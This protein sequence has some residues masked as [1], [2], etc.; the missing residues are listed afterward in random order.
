M[1]NTPPDRDNSPQ[2]RLALPTG[3]LLSG[4]NLILFLAAVSLTPLITFVFNHPAANSMSLRLLLAGSGALA[5][6]FFLKFATAGRGDSER[7]SFW[8]CLAA[9]LTL[10]ASLY[11]WLSFI[12]EI[13][14]SPLTLSWSEASR[15]YYA[16]LFFSER[17]YG[18]FVPPTVLHPSRYLLQAVPF[19]VPD[20]PIWVHRAWQ[21]LLWVVAPLIA[22]FV[23]ARRLDIHD[24]IQRWFFIGLAFL[25]I[26][27]GPIYYHLLV[28]VVLVLWGFRPNGSNADWRRVIRSLLVVLVASAWAGISRV[29][30]FPLP[31]CLAALLILLET[32]VQ[33]RLEAS[34]RT[35]WRAVG[36][37]LLRLAGWVCFGTATAFGSQLLYILWSGNSA[38]QF[39]TSFRS[40]LLW[41]RLLP[42][43]TYPLGILPAITLVS[44]P[45]ALIILGRLLEP[46]AG[47]P[48]WRRIHPLRLLG[49]LGILAVFFLGGLLV[50]VKIGG[51]SNLHNMDAFL[52]L[53]LVIAAYFFYERTGLDLQPAPPP[54]ASIETPLETEGAERGRPPLPRLLINA[55]LGLGFLIFPLITVISRPPAGP[56]PDPAEVAKGVAVISRMVRSTVQDGGSVLFLSYRE[57]L[58]FHR[59]QAPL[60]PDY[61]RVFLMEVAMADDPDY[62]RRFSDELKSQRFDLIVSEPISLNQKPD[63]DKFA[64]ENNAWVK[65]VSRPLLCYYKPIKTLRNVQV[66]LLAPRKKIPAECP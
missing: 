45:L 49:M 34:V 3:G 7:F 30:W 27:S 14:N 39:T 31:G 58:T 4:L 25:F 40:S 17:I 12:P 35:S 24:R 32:P 52:A 42:S 38:S 18:Q 63:R 43:Q 54:E 44:L 64:A 66:Q 41:R 50:S 2:R 15:Y 11:L 65:N 23:L 20:S 26:M 48:R 51:G 55:G 47:V 60:I 61:E 57:L 33:A 29:N 10:S 5:G 19:L 56:R 46:L 16:S 36:G 28:P 1:Q 22:S 59:V 62:L 21:A 9:S 6:A 8:V 37:Y 53:L 13:S